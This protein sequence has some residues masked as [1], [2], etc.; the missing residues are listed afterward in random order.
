LTLAN[1]RIEKSPAPLAHLKDTPLAQTI[2]P[3]AKQA[4][5]FDPSNGQKLN[6][7]TLANIRIE[8]SPAPLAYL[9]DTPLVQTT[10][11]I[12]KQARIF[13]PPN[14]QRGYI[15]CKQHISLPLLKELS[16]AT[17][18]IQ[19]ES[20]LQS[21]LRNPSAIWQKLVSLQTVF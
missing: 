3:I 20:K 10:E 9:K 17:E 2:E 8:K 19:R 14:G 11:L 13:D 4:R 6:I 12:A 7:L 18:E 15:N 1:F 21:C 5:N 16:V